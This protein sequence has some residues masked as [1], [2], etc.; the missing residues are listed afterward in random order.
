MVLSFGGIRDV[1]SNKILQLIF[2]FLLFKLI[3]TQFKQKI[4]TLK[5]FI[6][7]A[8]IIIIGLIKITIFP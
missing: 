7:F 3:L 4:Q 8:K 6:V 5:K 2:F 1:L